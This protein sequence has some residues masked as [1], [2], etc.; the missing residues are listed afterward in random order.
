MQKFLSK[1]IIF[2]MFP[3][4]YFGANMM[5]NYLFYTNQPIPVIKTNILIAGDSHP[6]KSLNPEYFNNAQNISQPAEPY[7]LTYWKLK[8]IFHSYIPD[9]L[10]I[11]FAPHNIS[12]FNDLKF[13]NE[14]WSSE[15]FKRSYPIE[16][17]DKISNKIPIDFTTFYKTLWKQTAFYPK[18]NHINYIG[19]YSNSKK[20]DISDSLTSVQRH[21]YLNGIEL[22]VSELAVNYLDSIVELCDSRKIELIIV[23][24]PVH[25][26]YLK[27]IPVKIMEKYI[28]LTKK[29][30]V[31]YTVFDKTTDRYPD[32]LFLNS[33]HLNEKGA[34]KFTEELIEYLK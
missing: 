12:E 16:Q 14:N 23:S 33:D 9:T 34:K 2:M 8:N 20:N 1:V 5:I 18:K 3:I 4:L 17:F 29:Y 19:S 13:S 31:N 15:M 24:N 22:G 25:K 27:K 11:G 32:S 7:V 28:E 30:N 10:I 6:Q 26:Q 21:Y